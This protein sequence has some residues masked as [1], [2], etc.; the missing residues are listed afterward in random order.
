MCRPLCCQV[1][2]TYKGQE[3]GVLDV[4]SRWAPNK[5]AESKACYGSTSLEHPAVHMVA[6]ERGR[7]YLGGKITGLDL[8]KRW[9]GGAAACRLAQ[10]TVQ[11]HREGR[12]KGME[13]RAAE[14]NLLVLSFAGAGSS[15]A[16]RP[17][18]CGPRCPTAPMWWPSSAGEAQLCWISSG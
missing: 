5:V 1:L 15:P 2:L 14:A 4:E 12:T 3:V 6:T 16:R 7:W 8:P 13:G 11:G 10:S 18:R 17:R 9:A